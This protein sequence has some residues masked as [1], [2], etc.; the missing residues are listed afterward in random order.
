MWEDDD[1]RVYKIWWL[2]S[3][4]G[5][6][7]KFCKINLEIWQDWLRSLKI[8]WFRIYNLDSRVFDDLYVYNGWLESL[9][10]LTIDKFGEVDL[11]VRCEW[12]GNQQVWYFKIDSV[13]L[14]YLQAATLHSTDLMTWESVGTDLKVLRSV[15]WKSSSLITYMHQK[16]DS[17]V[18]K[19]FL[20]V[21]GMTS[22]TTRIDL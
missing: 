7:L 8:W 4:E 11:E 21:F 22:K 20:F 12:L 17:E 9:W 16:N 10:G 13:Q 15:T 5:T 1:L 19:V 6:T 3:L 14:R 2:R 18:S